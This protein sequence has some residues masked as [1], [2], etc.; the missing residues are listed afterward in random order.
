MH[1]RFVARG[2]APELSPDG[3]RLAFVRDDCGG[4]TCIVVVSSAGGRPRPLGLGYEARWSPDSHRLAVVQFF[5]DDER[6]VTFDVAT[7]TPHAVAISERILG[8]GFS[9]DGGRIVF[10]LGRSEEQ[11]DVYVSRWGGGGVRRLTWDGRSTWPVWAP[12]GWID[13]AHREG[14]LGP[15]PVREHSGAY[16][17]VLEAWGKH[18]IWRIRPDGR[19]R[20]VLTRRLAPAISDARI[21]VRPLAWSGK[22]LLA[23]APLAHG[24]FPYLVDARGR[25]RSVDV[26]PRGAVHALGIS[27]DGRFLLLWNELDGPDSQRTLLE[28]QPTSGGPPRVIAP[29]VG[30]PSWSR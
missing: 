26:G 5:G 14:R 17:G 11:S 1:A 18:R 7:G 8:V 9:P 27:R 19:G 29:D 25:V 28:V 30:S 12:D 24:E 22:T 13:F 16:V 4:S 20:H 6:L 3:R 15:F 10:A 2:Y 21:G 23:V